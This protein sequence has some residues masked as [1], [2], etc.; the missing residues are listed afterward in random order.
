MEVASHGLTH[1]CLGWL[2]SPTCAY[3]ILQDRANLENDYNCMIR[4]FAY[5]YDNRNNDVVTALKESGFLYARTAGSTLGFDLPTDW[6]HWAGTCHHNHPQLREL[7]QA[8]LAKQIS[9]FPELFYLWGHSYEF[10]DDNNWHV[11][12]DFAQEI[13]SQPDIWYATNIEICEYV[14]AFR[15][16]V[17]SINGKSVYNPTCK[18][19]F[20]Q[21]GRQV[22]CV[23]PGETIC[24]V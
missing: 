12:E 21:N 14:T 3:E 9:G 6:Y 20:F 15:Q 23:H 16:L 5:P 17:F 11:I 13:G 4:G 19:L 22:V 1:L 7:V 18:E 8:F 10:E 24:L 2:P